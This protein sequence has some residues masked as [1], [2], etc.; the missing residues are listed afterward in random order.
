MDA[1]GLLELIRTRVAGLLDCPVAQV[2]PDLGFFELGLDS[3]LAGE[4]AAGL[5]AA[6]G[7][8]VDAILL[9]EY[10][11]PLALAAYLAELPAAA[12][13]PVASSP[14]DEP[15]AVVGM[16]C[17]VPGAANPAAFWELLRTGTDA[18]GEVPPD[19]WDV[20]AFYDPDPKAPGKACTRRGAFL[21]DVAGFDAAFFGVSPRE[22]AEMDPQQRLFLEVGWE[23]L[24]DA[25]LAADRLAGSST[26]VFAA[27]TGADYT[28]M[29]FQR[30]RPSQLDAYSLT[31]LAATFAAGRL[32][33]WLGLHG[34]SMSVDTACSSSLV[35]IHLACQSLRAGDC[36][37]ALA[38]G[39]NLL[40]APEMFVV[41]SKAGM[42]AP[43]GRCKT[44]DAG[45]DGYARGEGC[46]VVVLKPLSAAQADGDRVLA[47]IRGSAVNQDG[48]SS[49]ITVPNGSA[50]RAVVSRALEAAGVDG[51]RIGYV[52]AHGTGTAL[53]DPI[54]V[55]ALGA[56]LGQ[57]RSPDDPLM[58]GS[59]KTNIG[60]LEPA[61]GVAGLIKTILALRHEQVPPLLHLER[62]NPRIRL[63]ELPV[64]LPTTLTPWP[65]GSRPRLAGVSSFGAS[66]TNAH[67][68]VEEAPVAPRLPVDAERPAHLVTLSARTGEALSALVE[69]YRDHLAGNP[70]SLAD[71]GF[72][73]NHGRAHFGH[74][75]AVVADTAGQLRDRLSTMDVHRGVTRPGERPRVAFL[76]TGQGSQYA[77]MGRELYRTQPGFRRDL[78][79]CDALLRR[80]LDRSLL[81][82]IF[83]AAGSAALIN[84]T[85]YTQP[86][87]FA[88]QYAL[89]RLWQS[90]G[91][92]PAAVLGHSV[93]EYAAACVAGV[94]SL[95]DGLTLIAERARLMQD[96][97]PGGAMAALRAG[98][99][100]VAPALEPYRDQLSVAAVN[101]PANM[102]VSGVGAAIDELT[103]SLAAQG[104]KAT[105][106]TV[107]HA[108][109][110]PLIEPMLDAFE[111]HAEKIS[112]ATAEIPLVANLT[113]RVAEALDARYLREQAR[114]PVQFRAGA[115]ELSSLGC[116]AF[117]EIGPAPVLCGMARESIADGHW[118]PS[119]R[120][121]HGDWSTMLAS[122]ARLYV[123]GADIDW[124]GFD[125]DYRR[126]RVDLPTYPFARKRYWLKETAPRSTPTEATSLLGQRIPSPLSAAQ[127]RAVLTVDAHPGLGDC[128]FEGT[129]VVNAG[130]Y[131]DAAMAAAAE[132]HGFDR[133]EVTGLVLPRAFIMPAD[134]AAVT[135]L[136][137]EPAVNGSTPFRYFSQLST[138]DDQWALHAQGAV[139]AAGVV[140]NLEQGELEAIGARCHTAMSGRDFYESMAR[141][142]LRFGPSARWHDR[143]IV[144]DGEALSWMRAPDTGEVGSYRLH[145]GIVDAALQLLAVCAADDASVF[146]LVELESFVFNGYSGGPLLCHAAL[147]AR[148]GASG[149]MTADIRLVT[150]RGD[151]VASFRGVHMR[152][153]GR[154]TVLRVAG[155]APRTV[156]PAAT[157]VGDR[158][159]TALRQ[160]DETTAA[161]L[162]RGLLVERTAA[163]LGGSA[164]EIDE[165]EPLQH[166]GLDSLVAV[167]LRD[168]MT[169]AL[170]LPLP[171]ALFLD[172]PSVAGLLAAVLPR[173]AQRQISAQ[174]WEER[175]G[176]GGMHVAE[177]GSGE[178]IVFVHGGAVGGVDA[179]QTQLTLAKRWRLIIPSRLNYGRSLSSAREDFAEDAPLI[180]ELLGDG[181]HVVAQSYGTVGAM[182]AA[183]ARP[184]AVRSLTLIESGASGVARGHPVV[185]AFER[186]MLG[187]LA[188]P[189]DDPEDLF[190]AVFA[191][192][193]P[194]ARYASPLPPNLI[195]FA[196]RMASHVRWPWE[197]TIPLDALRAANIPTLVVSGGQR[198]VFEE[199]SDV[200]AARLHGERL[201]VPGGHATQNVGTAFN[202]ALEAF[203][204]R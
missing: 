5:S 116:T 80:H 18:T 11:N 199:I 113:G 201:V 137:T 178:P 59:V 162:L 19:R 65:R 123:A 192:I 114:A 128:V 60:H 71:I 35:A 67:V 36:S 14:A 88:L 63:D 102:V 87:L 10:P 83:P 151:L 186:A 130:F 33:Y 55:G 194:T 117:V 106:L 156:A 92:Q 82:V 139:A 99:D 100:R 29:R 126:R 34:P 120:P 39:V 7:R 38:G 81:S 6:L 91:V 93:G 170:D 28:Q 21:D 132:L 144:G 105:P 202:D 167:E 135:Q 37:L 203:L 189:P 16:A 175:T 40:L 4:L 1:A 32:S 48:R 115:H 146:M 89:A 73:A 85:R 150:E 104:I 44:F 138:L 157:G 101:G 110:S 195:T 147:L 171:A 75:L 96:L 31:G 94:L 191:I 46:G 111:R 197:A 173:L 159:R 124:A 190:R 187:L 42:M 43:D 86:A 141:R 49:G 196:K 84:Q 155:S 134:G 122:L 108:F 69:R 168:A 166:Q 20:A 74:R 163:V 183:A 76:F 22:A 125:R 26:G 176:P 72:T 9:F 103:D 174:Q 148:P 154:E 13:D 24:E 140:A 188:A 15:I 149:S 52:E 177:T 41:L 127:F 70:D 131:L 136:V 161:E 27:V 78:D 58:I 182:L 8:D 193:E 56:V 45:A 121:G 50:Q 97:P 153:I 79:R 77:G 158:V 133:I 129:A 98:I 184:G 66:G 90:W 169:A 119:L 68:I 143:I 62:V 181:A 47:V 142:G 17:R 152:Q 165:H 12:P 164:T 3:A 179:W 109:H 61:A 160:G 107:S 172:D 51:A 53:G 64:V 180:A 204:R 118:L 23:A 30:Y 2:E 54:E 57:G 200:L 112:Y 25:G 198:P 145:P 95:E 185:D